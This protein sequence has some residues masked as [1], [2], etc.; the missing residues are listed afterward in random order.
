MW[1]FAFCGVLVLLL[2]A[3]LGCQ[4]APVAFED[5]IAR[6]G[7]DVQATT[8]VI[9]RLSDDKIWVHNP[10]RANLRYSPASTSKIPHTLI[11]L[12]TGAATANTEFSWDG[13]VR[14]FAA[15]NQDQTLRSA[16]DRS[17][18]WVY[19]EL[20]SQLGPDVMSRWLRTFNYGNHDVGEGPQTSQYW[21]TGPLEISAQEQVA[22][23]TKLAES[24]WPLT[25]ETYAAARSLFEYERTDGRTL[26]A[27]TGWFYDPEAMD[28]GWF[29]GWV[30]QSRT[31]EI[32]VFALNMDMPT[33]EDVAKR[34][35]IVIDALR[36]IGA[37]P[38]AP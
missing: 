8:L 19:Q 30:E 22:F 31:S 17:A 11:A 10:A 4:N 15:W 32:Y 16:Y 26:Y 9:T 35:I 38:D 5:S 20:A 14:S 37:W 34:K 29:V 25:P 24:D 13:R 2:L 12:E 23:L 7:G 33:R 18:A 6:H 36:T 27:K 21:L 3:G 28:I 1:R